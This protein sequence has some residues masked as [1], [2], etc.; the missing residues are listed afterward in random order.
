VSENYLCFS[1][2]FNSIF[3][4]KLIFQMFSVSRVYREME[5]N[6]SPSAAPDSSFKRFPKL[7][8]LLIFFLLSS[9]RHTLRR[10]KGRQ[11]DSTKLFFKQCLLYVSNRSFSLHEILFIVPNKR[12]NLWIGPT[13]PT[14]RQTRAAR[15]SK[16]KIKCLNYVSF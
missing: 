15:N 3:L 16:G 8:F 13:T 4:L 9:T 2:H 11:R 5:P 10:V 6:S 7:F 14:P 1:K 12:Q